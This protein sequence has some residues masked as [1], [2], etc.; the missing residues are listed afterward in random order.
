MFA[1]DYICPVECWDATFVIVVV[2]V[3]EYYC[4]LMNNYCW[5]PWTTSFCSRRSPVLFFLN[6]ISLSPAFRDYLQEWLFVV[7]NAV[8]PQ[9]LHLKSFFIFAKTVFFQFLALIQNHV[10]SRFFETDALVQ[11]PCSFVRAKL[12]KK[13][14]NL[15]F[16]YKFILK[17]TRSSPRLQNVSFQYKFVLN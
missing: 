10:F 14:Q 1:L 17:L 9:N 15:C 6:I 8:V 11:A 5:R 2:V 12:S 13:L 4:F 3:V 7:V 16:Q